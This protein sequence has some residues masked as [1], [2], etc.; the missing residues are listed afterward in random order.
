MEAT[1]ATISSGGVRSHG[2]VLAPG[3]GHRYST[4]TGSDSCESSS[5]NVACPNCGLFPAEEDQ[6]GNGSVCCRRCRSP[7]ARCAGKS[8]DAALA[9]ALAT[10]LLLIPISFE[11]FLTTYALGETRT[12]ILPSSVSILWQEGLPVLGSVIGLFVLIFPAIRFGALSAVLLTVRTAS[13]P[14]WLGALFRY[15][16]ALETWAM[17]DVFLLGFVVA[18]ARLRVSIVVTIEIGAMCYIA[19]AV[20]SL[21]VRATLDKAR[22]WQLIAPNSN[23]CGSRPSM[24]CHG[25]GLP[26]TQGPEA[27]RCPRCRALL[28]SRKPNS[29]TTPVALL[30]AA[31][32]LY[33][34]ANLY[35]IARI[36]IDLQPTSYTVIGGIVDLVQGQF[37]ALAALVFS[38]S[39]A[40][41]LLKIFG[42]SWC[43]ASLMRRSSQHLVGKTRIYRWLEEIGRWS[44]IDPFT[45][46][47][48]VPVIHF[49]SL[50]DG[51]AEPAATPFAA[52]VILTTLAV[53]AFDSRR[54]WDVAEHT[55]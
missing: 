13:R 18:Y 16:N 4:N 17:L 27:C 22:V 6:F 11:P 30:I 9:C 32:L 8:L 12:S 47:C 36:P 1:Q 34:P 42:L 55:N 25:C 44:M 23:W 19:A 52:V 48:F 28:R 14:R 26:V 24:N 49:N 33:F 43:A 7:L 10:C 5:R 38:A 15:A 54:M 46:A 51:R 53:K 2:A 37:Y 41:P 21:F 45:I 50:I 39:F 35:P 3:I 40:I 29:L 20:L 31:A